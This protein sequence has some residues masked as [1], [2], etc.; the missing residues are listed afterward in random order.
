MKKIF[1]VLPVFL[2]C[3]ILIMSLL[4]QGCNKKPPE[5]PDALDAGAGLFTDSTHVRTDEYNQTFNIQYQEFTGMHLGIAEGLY[6]EIELNLLGIDIYDDYKEIYAFFSLYDIR[7]NDA[8]HIYF[9]NETIAGGSYMTGENVYCTKDDLIS[10]KYRIPLIQAYT[11]IA[12]P[13]ILYGL[14]DAIFNNST[15]YDNAELKEY[16][17]NNEDISVLSLYG[18]RFYKDWNTDKEIEIAVQ[19]SASLT[20]YILDNYG[21]DTLLDVSDQIKIEWLNS[22]GVNKEYIDEYDGLF[23]NYKYSWSEEYSMIIKTDTYHYHMYIFEDLKSAQDA[24]HF[25]YDDIIAKEYVFDYLMENVVENKDVIHYSSP[26]KYYVWPEGYSYISSV[27]SIYIRKTAFALH[28][29]VHIIVPFSG[30]NDWQY[31]GIAE[32]ISKVVYKNNHDS[33]RFA[34]IFPDMIEKFDS[35]EYNINDYDF[36][37]MKCYLQNNGGWET[38][39][40][41][42]FRLYADSVSYVTLLIDKDFGNVWCSTPIYDRLNIAEFAR[43][44]GAELSYAQAMSFTAFLAEKYSLDAFIGFCQSGVTFDE[45]LGEDYETLKAEWMDYLEELGKGNQ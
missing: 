42:D 31:E 29:F 3:T 25:I 2:V 12:Q 4:L 20:Q 33:V 39:E 8:I 40:D 35:G 18:T 28:E 24:E 37:I 34:G 43:K 16:Y 9:Q 26:I 17:Q 45:A 36:Q 6:E 41:F 22:I 27:D 15:G 23:H 30:S 19:T 32:Y 1:K 38:A 11:G 13:W 7:N 21:Y 10:G 44:P 14:N 5:M